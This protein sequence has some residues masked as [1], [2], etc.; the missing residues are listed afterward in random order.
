MPQ[1]LQV[2]FRDTPYYVLRHKYAFISDK[3]YLFGIVLV[4]SFGIYHLFL[5]FNLIYFI[6]HQKGA[7]L[8]WGM[9][10]PK[11]QVLWISL[12]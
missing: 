6:P 2:I 7:L 1:N 9:Y 12:K 3:L 10:F 5:C 8:V 11:Q 4:P